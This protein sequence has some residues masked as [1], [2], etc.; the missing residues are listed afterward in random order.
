[1]K[2][3]SFWGNK[4]W[5]LFLRNADVILC[6]NC[7]ILSKELMS[8]LNKS[9]IHVEYG[10]HKINPWLVLINGIIHLIN[11][12]NRCYT[13]IPMMGL[14]AGWIDYKIDEQKKVQYIFTICLSVVFYSPIVFTL[15]RKWVAN[16]LASSVASIRSPPNSKVLQL[17]MFSPKFI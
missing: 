4:Q 7:F 15:L 14:R 13:V 3:C 1:M 16:D 17:K 10:C 11:K 12:G 6:K 2:Y 8:P 5:K 9:V